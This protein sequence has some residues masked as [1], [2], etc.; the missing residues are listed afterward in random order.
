MDS[1]RF[2]ADI[3][4]WLDA[5]APQSIR[6]KTNANFD[7]FWGGRNFS[8]P[9]DCYVEWLNVAVDKGI[10][11][12][13]WPTEYG[14][15][16]YSKA[17]EK[18]IIEEMIKLRLP[19]PLIGLGMY[20]IGPTILDYGTEAQK[21]FF[22]PQIARGE[23]R[24]CQGFSEPG[25]GSDLASLRT[26]AKLDEDGDNFIVN[27]QKIWTSYGHVSDWIFTLV[28]TKNSDS[29]HDGIT[30]LLVDLESPGVTVKPIELISGA[31]SFCETF[32]DDVRVPKENVLGAVDKG[33]EVAKTLLMYERA[34][35][36]RAMG[37][38]PIMGRPPKKKPRP[39]RDKCS[40]MGSRAID[41]HGE[42]NGALNNPTLRDDI[43]KF[44]M[45]QTTHKLLGESVVAHTQAKQ[46]TQTALALKIVGMEMNQKRQELQM[47][48]SGPS[49][50]GWEGAGFTEDEIGSTREWLRSRANSIE[51]GTSEIQLNILAK[52]VL[53][54]PQE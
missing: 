48:I 10:T 20:F 51:G 47:K 42:V 31:S 40:F 13:T 23:I 53:G 33:W 38:W 22:L 44:E 30:F 28:R 50:L 3:H 37:S 2:R 39:K 25:A 1:N 8:C 32:Y 4:A 18:I 21:R 14:G 49:G 27:G 5:N 29:K 43:A 6:T 26:S 52:R 15:G 7:G 34:A 17:E 54:L 46:P 24:W 9:D 11:A 45:Q 12:P 16:G 41:Y 19:P 36:S 35:I